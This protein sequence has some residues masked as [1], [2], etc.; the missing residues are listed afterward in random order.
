MSPNRPAKIDQ[1]LKVLEELP[2]L[3]A[4]FNRLVASLAQEDVSFARIAELIERDT[5]VAGNV[6]SVVNS[7]LFGLRSQVNSVRHAVALLGINKLRTFLWSFAA[8]S[9]WRRSKSPPGYSIR[10]FNL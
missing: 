6:L 10:E 1:A 8:M 2:P 4:T 9:S 5:V 3:S 7:A